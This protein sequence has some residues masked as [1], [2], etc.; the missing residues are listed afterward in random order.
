VATRVFVEVG[1][2]RVFACALDWPGWCR[3]GKDEAQALEALASAAPRYA[4]VAQDAGISFPGDTAFDVVERLPG[5]SGTDFG[6][7]GELA[8]LDIEPQAAEDAERQARLLAAAWRVFDAVAASAPASLRKGPR[9]GGRDRDAIIDH[10]LG[11]EAIYYARKLGVRLG[12][13]ARDDVSAIAAERSQIL[14]VLSRPS[15]GRPAVENGWLPRHAARR[16]AWHVLDHA[17][18]IEDR[19]D[20]SS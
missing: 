6:V 5:S 16:I 3:S 8:S 14:A 15:D 18:E 1:Q 11:A 17:W 10:V 12:Q 7:P 20:L 19:S 13:P 4:R 9:G 2:K